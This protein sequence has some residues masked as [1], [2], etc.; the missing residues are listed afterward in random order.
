MPD[1][2]APTV[3]PLRRFVGMVALVTFVTIYIFVVLV[4]GSVRFPEGSDT[5]P[6]MLFYAVAGLLWVVPAAWLIRWMY[7]R[8]AR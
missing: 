5:L 8:P 3:P 2:T 6:M 7:R 4:I 1:P